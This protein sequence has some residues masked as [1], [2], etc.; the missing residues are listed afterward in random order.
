MNRRPIQDVRV[1]SIQDRS[2]SPS[3]RSPYLVRWLVDGKEHS[4]SFR[5][6]AQ[7]DRYRSR[8]LVAAQ[9]G[10]WFDRRTGEPES[11]RPPADATQVHAWARA[12][13]LEQ[14]HEWAP[15]TRQSN[16]E[17][18]CRFLP[19]VVGP[20][21]PAPPA[22]VRLY[23][24]EVLRPDG[25]TLGDTESERWLGKWGCRWGSSTARSWRT[26]SVGC[27]CGTTGGC[28]RCRRQAATARS[29]TPASGAPSSSTR[30]RPTRGRRHREGGAGG[31]YD[32]SGLPL[33]CGCCRARRRWWRCS[34]RSRL[35]SRG[36]GC[37]R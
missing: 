35:T 21:A 19:L 23:L 4:L 36:A 27:R 12:W 28:W 8:L 15:R 1:W 3:T 14:W 22:G 11:W 7:A 6:R 30:S 26:S 34:M 2:S 20:G 24:R 13:V 29:R 25:S 5:V 10:E 17:A 32:G 37:T 9:D 18:L 31:R 16:V 33:T